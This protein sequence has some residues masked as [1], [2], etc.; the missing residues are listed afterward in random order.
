MNHS[1]GFAVV[2]IVKFRPCVTNNHLSPWKRL[3]EQTHVSS[4]LETLQEMPK[5]DCRLSPSWV[6]I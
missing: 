1:P 5:M 4:T 2:F 6:M 3:E